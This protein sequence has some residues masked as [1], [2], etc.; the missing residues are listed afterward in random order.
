MS[1]S[2]SI[3]GALLELHA[4]DPAASIVLDKRR[5]VWRERSRDELLGEVA[6]LAEGLSG[7]DLASGET[8]LLL[9]E[10]GV[11]WVAMDL[12]CQAAGLRV[13]A[14][15]MD[16]PDA[17]LE[18]AMRA[19]NATVVV[20]SGYQSIERVLIAAE[21]LAHPLRVVYD[22][23]E[24]AAG[25]IRDPR[26]LSITALEEAGASATVDDLA[27]R[28]AS[29]RGS[30]VAVTAIGTAAERGEPAVELRHAALLRTA[31]LVVSAFE[32][33][34]ADR[35]LSFRPLADPTDR[36]T[37]LYGALI[38]G[39][40]LVIPESRAEVAVAMYET[41]PT[42]VHVTRRWVDETTTT[43]WSRLDSSV[44]LK[45]LI[46]R[47]WLK[48]LTTGRALAG[49]LATVLAR[50]PILEKLGLDKARVLVLSGSALGVPERRFSAAL[51]LPI[52]P[53]YAITEAG[54]V[55][56]VA[57]DLSGPP[58]DCGRPMPGVA[59][60][61]DASGFIHLRDE[62]SGTTLDTLDSGE[63]HEGRLVLKGRRSDRPGSSPEALAESLELEVALR[64][65]LLVREAVVEA[66][67]D[68]TTV[69]VE[70]I[71]PTLER[72]AQGQ[73]ISFATRRSL[74]RTDEVVEHLREDVVRA[75][76]EH[77]LQ[78]I[79]RFIVLDASIDSI[80]GAL[81]SSGRVRRDVVL[82]AA[83]VY[84]SG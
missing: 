23:H 4:A 68:G 63:L 24:L 29:L 27:G 80:P 62:E 69:V 76:V 31:Q 81:S 10:D 39:A 7:I 20:A 54:G 8:V 17:L 47:Q 82:E 74:V 59:L 19:S 2:Q 77:G 13:C 34:A 60:T 37:T 72:W 67:N 55:I 32:L 70:P 22:T 5:G 49:P 28:A 48:R 30:D 38:S 79:D 40:T 83:R 78:T 15:P 1:T 57:D 36:C 66:T 21:R 16:A 45:G 75:G 12:A 42:F 41:A 43:I 14:I 53:A 3:I 46:A 9:A 33:D 84:A 65:S 64:S 71:F 50:Y 35:V 25:A 61:V 73:D 52:R 56:A 6:R 58:G 44:G 18:A 51:G 26:H 11:A